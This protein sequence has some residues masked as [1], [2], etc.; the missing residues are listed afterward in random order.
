MGKYMSVAE[1]R[2]VKACFA[3]AGYSI[4]SIAPKVEMS[5]ETLS[6]R[7]NGRTDFLRSEMIRIAKILRK[8][9]EEI[10]LPRKLR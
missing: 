3:E 9:P 6:S 10:F 4:T 8:R 2:I 7:V 5:R 1:T